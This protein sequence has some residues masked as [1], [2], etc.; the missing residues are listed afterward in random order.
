MSHLFNFLSGIW[1]FFATKMI[2]VLGLICAVFYH[3]I[4][5]A[6]IQA[7]ERKHGRWK[8]SRILLKILMVSLCINVTSE[9][10]ASFQVHKGFW[11]VE[12]KVAHVSSVHLALESLDTSSNFEMLLD[13]IEPHQPFQVDQHCANELEEFLECKA[14]CCSCSC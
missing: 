6:K 5:G 12:T 11:P 7:F 4:M 2:M 13:L 3:L 8:L 14:L 9:Q 10:V 1:S